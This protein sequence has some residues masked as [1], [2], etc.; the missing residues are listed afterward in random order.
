MKTMDRRDFISRAAAAG[1]TLGLS[2]PAMA[3]PFSQSPIKIGIVGLD[4]SHS[5]AFAKYFNVTD[6]SG[7]FRV[8]AAYPHGSKDIASSVSRIPK[9]TD[10]VKG[11]GVSVVDSIQKL[12]TMVDAVLL[13]TNDGRLH[14]EQA[15]Q[16]LQARKPVFIDKPVAAS[17][18]DV[19]GIYDKARELNVP[20]F[21]SS[22]LRYMKTAQD[23]RY[24]NVIGNVLGADTFSPATLEPTHPD[25]FWYGIHGVEILFTV[26]G[27]GCESVTRFNKDNMDVVVGLW[28]DGRIGTFRGTREGKHDYGGT[29]FGSSGNLVLGPFDGYDGLAVKIAEFFKTKKSPVDEKETLEIYAFM[30]AAHESK[31][32]RGKSVSLKEVSPK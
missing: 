17:L 18:S 22:S 21:S 26:M 24:Q 27:A 12:L 13:E 7:D 25:L 16:I 14:K 19:F 4:T 9:Y 2:F 32:H 6:T 23:V 15:F 30:E 29:A 11:Y 1:T 28:A 31:R 8:V 5:P 10:E 3:T 20:V